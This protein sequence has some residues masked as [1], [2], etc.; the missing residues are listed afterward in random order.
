MAQR[1]EAARAQASAAIVGRG[2]GMKL[3]GGRTLS[4]ATVVDSNTLRR[5]RN[6]KTVRA[7]VH[8]S[9]DDDEEEIE[10]GQVLDDEDEEYLDASDIVDGNDSG[11]EF[12]EGE[13]EEDDGAVVFNNRQQRDLQVE[14]PGRSDKVDRRR[15][16]AVAEEGERR[17]TGGAAAEERSG[18][19]AS[20]VSTRAASYTASAPRLSQSSA[21]TVTHASSATARDTSVE[22]RPKGEMRPPLRVIPPVKWIKPDKYVPPAPIESYLSHFE[23]VA[24]YNQWDDYDKTA[25]LKAALSTEAAQLLW[26]GGDH[27]RMTY[28]DVVSKLRSRFGSAAHNERYAARLRMLK[29]RDGQDLQD[30]HNEVCKLMALA[31]PGTAQTKLNDVF[32]RDAFIAALNDRELEIKVRDR[33]PWDLESAFQA[34]T[35]VE[36][37]LQPLTDD[38]GAYR[39][40]RPRRDRQDEQ[41][42]A[43]QVQQRDSG[44]DGTSTLVKELQK[45]I[46]GYQRTQ[47]EMD[48]KLDRI[49]LLMECKTSPSNVQQTDSTPQQDQRRPYDDQRRRDGACYACGETGHIARN[50]LTRL[51]RASKGQ[52]DAK[53]PAVTRQ[54]H[55]ADG[56]RLDRAAYLVMRIRR[57]KVKCL[58]DTGSEVCLFPARYADADGREHNG[59]RLSA[60]NG[61]D[62]RIIG[63]VTIEAEL[64][65]R[66]LT[67]QGYA[68]PH[69]SEVILGLGFLKTHQVFWNFATG[70]VTLYGQN[71]KL[72]DRD[73]KGACRRVILEENI[74]APPRSEIVLPAYVKYS[75]VIRTSGEWSTIP[76]QLG[77]HLHVARTLLP[78]RAYN[79]PV[80]LVNTGDK[81]ITL[82]VGTEIAEV[83]KVEVEELSLDGEKESEV[84][85]KERMIQEMMDKVN[86]EVG[87]SEKQVL[88]Q[89][90]REYSEAF[91]FS[92]LDIGHA[93]ACKH[94]IDVGDAPPVRQR[95]RRQPPAHQAAADEHV[96]SMLEQGIIEPAQSPWAANIVMVLKKS[97]EYRCCVDYRALNQ[98][99]KKDAYCLPRIDVCLD[100]MAGAA[101]FST[102]DL[103]SSYYQVEMDESSKEKTAFICRGGQYQHVRMPMGL[104]NS[105]ATFQRLID[106]VLTGLSYDVCMA[107]IDDIIVYSR[108]LEEHFARL[109]TVLARLVSAKLKIKVSKTFLLQRSVSFLGH[110]ISGAGIRAHPD[111][112]TQILNWGRPSCVKD[113][114]AFIGLTSY[115]RKFVNQY[116]HIVAPLTALL[117]KNKMFSWTDE[118]EHA[119]VALKQALANPPLL[120]MPVQGQPYILD[121]DASDF[122]IGGVLSQVQDGETRVIAYASR[123]L[124]SRERNYCVTRRELL[125]VVNYLKFFRAYLLGATPPV[126]IRTDHAALTWLKN[127]PEPVGQQARWL[128][129]M[130]EYSYVIEH[131]AGRSHGNAD[132]MSRD[133]CYNSRCCP[134]QQVTEVTPPARIGVVRRTETRALGAEF[135]SQVN[136]TSEAQKKDVNIAPIMELIASN[137]TKPAWD[138]VQPMAEETKV[139]WRQWDRLII[140]ESVLVRIFEEADGTVTWPQVIMPREMRS[141]F[142]RDLHA[143]V[144]GGHLG[145]HRTELSVRARAYWPGWHSDVRRAL[146]ACIECAQFHRGQPA[147]SAQLAPIVCGEPWEL[148]SLDITGPHTTSSQGHVYIL[149]M[150]DNFTKWA[151][152]F[153]IR[154]HTAPIVANILFHQVIMRFGCPRRILTDR[155]PEFEGTLMSELCKL[156]GIDKVRSTPYHP[157][158]NGMLERFHRTLNSMLGKVVEQNQRDWHE[159]LAPVMAAYRATVH[160]TTG[161]TP[162]RLMFG[163]EV[164]LPVDLAYGLH[165]E[166]NSSGNVSTDEYVEKLFTRA[167]EDFATAREKLNKLAEIRKKRYDTKVNGQI[168]LEPGQLVYYFCPR[169]YPNKSPKWQKMFTGPYTVV[170]IIDPHVIVIRKSPRSKTFT[171]HRDKLKIVRREADFPDFGEPLNK[172]STQND[173]REA[174]EGQGEYE[175]INERPKRTVAK[176]KRFEQ[177]F[178]RYVHLCFK[179]EEMPSCDLCQRQFR[180]GADLRR[181]ITTSNIHYAKSRGLPTPPRSRQGLATSDAVRR[182]KSLWP[183]ER[184][185]RKKRSTT[186]RRRRPQRRSSPDKLLRDLRVRLIR[187]SAEPNAEDPSF[188]S[189]SSH[190]QQNYMNDNAS[191]ECEQMSEVESMH[192]NQ[193]PVRGPCRVVELSS[194]DSPSPPE[195]DPR[196]S[197]PPRYRNRVRRIVDDGPPTAELTPPVEPVHAELLPSSPEPLSYYRPVVEDISEP[198]LANAA[199]SVERAA[200]T[201]YELPEVVSPL[202][203]GTAFLIDRLLNSSTVSEDQLSCS[204]LER[205]SADLFE[206]DGEIESYRCQ[207]RRGSP[208]MRHVLQ[209]PTPFGDLPRTSLL[210]SSPM[211][212]REPSFFTPNRRSPRVAD[213]LVS[214]DIA[215]SDEDRSN[216]EILDADYPPLDL[217]VDV[218]SDVSRA[219]TS[220]ADEPNV[221]T[222]KSPYPTAYIDLSDRQSVVIVAFRSQN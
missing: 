67:I 156:M 124:S 12:S 212:H 87:D 66:K 182:R 199:E 111:K 107:Y 108:T 134:S 43:R 55:D 96:R 158:V 200:M 154:R 4:T 22:T 172:V 7:E 151:E 77:P 113:V 190:V 49:R 135:L 137:A 178:C 208:A 3:R 177:Y 50:C 129:T 105:G 10:E 115:Y 30:L 193:P 176:P 192:Q 59:Q 203:A 54:V 85:V 138:W 97:G 173:N 92:D 201:V 29:R 89:L 45:R 2:E 197:L 31:Y 19:R 206:S 17:P 121:T 109:R 64:E 33:D 211:I 161:F 27:A 175:E 61:T 15:S 99:T 1:K 171:A 57:R 9:N 204:L 100:A 118:C 194:V 170:R 148:L 130:Q 219:A 210:E 184:L 82:S 42:R 88:K 110:Q 84:E 185:P 117:G 5:D 152:A 179:Q 39:E 94:T 71:F 26:D 209:L 32:A 95:L 79:I 143:G 25:H 6:Q 126:R 63:E 202:S 76:R 153:A 216:S 106:I 74:E 133:P 166:L 16:V 169:R 56:R 128:E 98:V 102:F 191:D 220:C 217:S 144:G 53:E 41:H 163:R 23:T 119:F 35:K 195:L 222:D 8:H 68:S 147:R 91:S 162:N 47:E 139:L 142:L 198:S 69:V 116:A 13:G 165:N 122:A 127:I 28:E 180:D 46:D 103:R 214:D 131:R 150:Q 34:A 86:E 20:R 157:Q 123:R 188:Q 207:S 104:C 218:V 44:N 14:A 58:L 72:L 75:G 62:I 159:H 11:Q 38:R 187:W 149:T 125:A 141:K 132:G 48:K 136:E 36:G 101:W 168:P 90:L 181:H 174:T 51:P 167:S 189:S 215:R 65:G 140:M 112:T 155:G 114:R 24:T 213:M 186:T 60:A 73:M 183:I 145:R 70:V 18:P 146:K 160:E 205:S 80:R 81:K 221:A 83:E 40:T 120:A 52:T 93:T 78:V 37:Y 164:T 196:D 21:R